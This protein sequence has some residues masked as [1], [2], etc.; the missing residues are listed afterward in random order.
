[1]GVFFPYMR[2]NFVQKYSSP[3]KRKV[4]SFIVIRKTTKQRHLFYLMHVALLALHNN[5]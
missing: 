3:S 4:I 1:M 2:T 5:L